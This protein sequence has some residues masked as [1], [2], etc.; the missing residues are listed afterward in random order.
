M[1]RYA[2]VQD[3][4][5]TSV[6]GMTIGAHGNF[7][8]AITLDQFVVRSVFGLRLVEPGNGADSNLVKALRGQAPFGDDVTPPAPGAIFPR[9]PFD[10]SPVD[11]SNIA[12]IAKWIDDGCPDD[13]VVEPKTPGATTTPVVS[14][15]ERAVVFFR[16]FDDFFA[17]NANPNTGADLDAFMLPARTVWPGWSS[18]LPVAG[19]VGAI[20]LVKDAVQRL[21]AGQLAIMRNHYGDPLDAAAFA[22]ALWRFGSGALPNDPKRPI[23]PRH[24]MNGASMWLVWLACGD[25]AIRLQ[26]DAAAWST[27]ARA[28]AGGLVADALFRVDRPLPSRLKITRYTATQPNVRDQ[29][30][31]DMAGLADASLVDHNIG[32]GREARGEVVMV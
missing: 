17:F 12:F 9:M 21:S 13:D 14:P 2:K 26:V 23:D 16:E 7:W 31:Q 5:E 27:V 19:W 11:D 15:D 22:D 32:L 8:R 25:A 3:I 20:T 24:R 28:V 4:L 6:G 29:V 30:L 10:L 18:Q 1:K